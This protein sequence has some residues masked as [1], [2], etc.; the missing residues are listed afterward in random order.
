M[1][2]STAVPDP[3]PSSSASASYGATTT[4]SSPPPASA[5][6]LDRT[7]SAEAERAGGDNLTSLPRPRRPSSLFRNRSVKRTAAVADRPRTADDAASVSGVSLSGAN[8]GRTLSR[9]KPINLRSGAGGWRQLRAAV[10]AKAGLRKAGTHASV[11]AIPGAAPGIDIENESVDGYFAD[12][13]QAAVNAMVVDFDVEHMNVESNLNNDRLINLLGMPRPADAAVRWIHIEGISWDVLRCL[14]KL[15]KLHPLSVED[16]IHLPQRVKHD[17]YPQHLYISLLACRLAATDD[18]AAVSERG[19][20]T[21]ETLN[22]QRLRLLKQRSAVVEDL[23]APLDIY[24]DSCS[25]FLLNDNTLISMTHFD[26]SYVVDPI[27]ARLSNAR[28]MVRT[29]CDASFLANSLVDSIVDHYL[30]IMDTYQELF[31]RIEEHIFVQPTI[32]LIQHVHAT[33]ANLI[34]LKQKLL[35]VQALVRSLRLSS[36]ATYD[37]HVEHKASSNTLSSLATGVNGNGT[38]LPRLADRLTFETRVYLGDVQDHID[39][40]LE[41]IETLQ[42]W[43]QN[44]TDLAFNCISYQTNENMKLLT[45]ASV[46]FMPLTFIAGYFGMNFKTFPELEYENAIPMFWLGCVVISIL[47]LALL[48]YKRFF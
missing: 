1:E 40:V 44:M 28:T 38:A 20:P 41:N 24:A 36:S 12:N 5:A 13:L 4:T 25:L 26:A 11:T 33:H 16:A 47:I 35:P 31:E 48:K 30:P 2:K 22:R 23:E 7:A 18:V 37:R 14:T 9:G 34:E 6:T 10:R 32:K 39:S 21:L 19:L 3:S 27:V 46:V 15:Y 43:A 42:G 8:V 29:L 45:V 17:V